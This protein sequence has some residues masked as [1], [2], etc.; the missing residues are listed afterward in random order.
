MS[1]DSKFD[2]PFPNEQ[3][4]KSSGLNVDDIKEHLLDWLIGCYDGGE[5]IC[6][7]LPY[8]MSNIE[9]IF[10][11][12]ENP[13]L[14]KTKEYLKKAFKKLKEERIDEAVQKRIDDGKLNLPV[15]NINVKNNALKE[16][17]FKNINA[18]KPEFTGVRSQGPEKLLERTMDFRIDKNKWEEMEYENSNVKFEK[19]IFS[20]TAQPKSTVQNFLEGEIKTMMPNLLIDKKDDIWDIKWGRSNK[21]SVPLASVNFDNKYTFEKNVKNELKDADN[22]A[23]KMQIL[24]RIFNGVGWFEKLKNEFWTSKVGTVSN[25]DYLL[26]PFIIFG[27]DIKI[28][29]KDKDLLGEVTITAK[30]DLELI[31]FQPTRGE[32]LR[33]PAI[34]EVL[35]PRSKQKPQLDYTAQEQVSRG[36]QQVD[37]GDMEIKYDLWKHLKENIKTLERYIKEATT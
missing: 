34:E 35:A 27:Y 10:S 12:K 14:K 11:D 25:A 36:K 7:L 3:G 24:K 20:F 15:P 8:Y 18:P 13:N 31:S 30:P 26:N 28:E 21:A 32:T 9:E 19:G 2:M 16:W 5:T 4:F 23:Q 37:A 22:N 29:V 33:E 6:N 17:T 1:D